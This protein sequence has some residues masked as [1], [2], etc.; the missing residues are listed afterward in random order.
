MGRAIGLVEFKSIAKGVEAADAMLKA[1]NIELVFS[2]PICPGKYIS[3]ITGEVG[4][5][6]YSVEAARSIS[7]YF[8]ISSYVIPN[9]SEKVFPA[10]SGTTAVSKIQALGIVETMSAISSVIAGDI[11][12]KSS[13]VELIE[14]RIARGLGGKGFTIITGDVASVKSAV[15]SCEEGLKEYGDLVASTVI[16]S[17]SKNLL[18]YIY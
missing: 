2:S 14:I 13:N 7:E 15:K 3:I 17:P 1:G 9:I 18:E 5:V 12:V 4:A 11:A 6:E 10:I 16:P 8:L